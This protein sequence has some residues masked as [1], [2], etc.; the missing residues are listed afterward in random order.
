[1]LYESEVTMSHSGVS[2]A[3]PGQ[4]ARAAARDFTRTR[5]I[6]VVEDDPAITSSLMETLVDEGF[7][8][9]AAANGREALERL[10]SG[11]RPAAIILDLMMPVMDG[12]DFRSEQLKDPALR[13]IP[14]VV[15]TAAGFSQNTI[16]TQFGDVALVPKPVPLPDLLN[17]LGR[18]CDLASSAA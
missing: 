18:V 2:F 15:V 1:M 5:Q 13:D 8:V 11:L 4:A 9:G 10:R 6:L 12:W 14:V 16:R 3:R 7:E 17:A